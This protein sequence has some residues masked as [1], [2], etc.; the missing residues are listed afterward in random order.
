[1]KN[2]LLTCAGRRNYIV[3]YF[4]DVLHE[5][6]GKV[7]AANSNAQSSALSVADEGFIVPSLYEPDYIDVLLSICHAH[8]ITAIIPL[9]DLELPI[10]AEAKSRL[11]DNGVWA[12]V[13]SSEVVEICNDKWLTNKFLIQQGLLCPK[14]Y[15]HIETLMQALDDGEIDFPVMIKPRWG[16]GSIGIYEADNIDEL[17]VLLSKTLRAIDNSYIANESRN[18]HEHV[19]LFQEKLAGEEYGLDIINNLQGKYVTTLVKHKISM[20]SGETDCAVTVK[21]AMLEQLGEKLGNVLGHVGN[22]DADIIVD[23]TGPHILELNPRIGGGYPFSHL[24]GAN[25]P[26]AI[27]SWLEGNKHDPS[28]LN[29]EYGVVGIKGIQ[30]MRLNLILAP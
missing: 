15:H 27:L 17:I 11:Y 25:L 10:L 6:G 7:F 23:K 13:S 5:K 9:F 1:M 3:E 14:T 4:Q 2:I 28:D 19:V 16:M 21:N 30:P 26:K 22:L 29:I 18:N 20:R 8:Q 12:V 24:A